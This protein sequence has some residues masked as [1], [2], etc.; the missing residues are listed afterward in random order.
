MKLISSKDEFDFSLLN[1]EI[2]FIKKLE[3]MLNM[4]IK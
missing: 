4:K 3:E 2:I 1:D